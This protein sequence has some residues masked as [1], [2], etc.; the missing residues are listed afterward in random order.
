MPAPLLIKKRTKEEMWI[1]PK[2]VERIPESSESGSFYCI[3][4]ALVITWVLRYNIHWLSYLLVL[5]SE[6]LTRPKVPN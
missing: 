3:G 6:E 1:T 2:T 4:L 5:I